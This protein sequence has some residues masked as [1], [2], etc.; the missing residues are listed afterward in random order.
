MDPKG[1]ELKHVSFYKFHNPPIQ[2]EN[3]MKHKETKAF[4]D[5]VRQRVRNP[6]ISVE[7]NRMIMT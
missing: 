4:R 2:E 3:V 5:A 6:W 1:N 7:I